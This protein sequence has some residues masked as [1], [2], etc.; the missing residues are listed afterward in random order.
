MAVYVDHAFAEGDWGRWT[1]GGHLQA[2]TTAELHAFA[3]ALGLRREWF[4]SCPGRPEKDHYDLTATGR[5]QAVE[6]GARAEDRRAGA[7]RRRAV[8]DAHRRA[9]AAAA[10]SA[11]AA[12]L[13]RG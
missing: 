5:R 2:D 8:R 6:L 9:S 10:A 13:R 12:G 11:P 3:A 4:Q 7:H 1:G